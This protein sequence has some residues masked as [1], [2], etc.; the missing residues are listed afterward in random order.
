MSTQNDVEERSEL[1]P[2]GWVVGLV[3]A[4]CGAASAVLFRRALLVGLGTGV[5]IALFFFLYA[6]W[7]RIKGKH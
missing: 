5:G 4:V 6:V 2:P 7:L 1:M 3:G